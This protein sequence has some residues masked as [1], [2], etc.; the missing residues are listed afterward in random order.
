MDKIAVKIFLGLR[1]NIFLDKV[2][3]KIKYTSM[4]Q[5]V[6]KNLRIAFKKFSTETGSALEK[7][8]KKGIYQL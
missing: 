4:T 3:K 2:L 6:K 7:K 1:W 5:R 8:F